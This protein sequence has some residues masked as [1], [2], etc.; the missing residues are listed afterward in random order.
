VTS[1]TAAA[2]SEPPRGAARRRLIVEGAL[3][4]LARVGP[5]GLTHRLVAA[6]AGVPLAATTYWFASKEAIVEAA[7]E[8]SVEDSL[9][10]IAARREAARTWTRASAAHELALVIQQECSTDREQTVVG[11][12]LWV[13]ALRR[14]AL[15]P[16]AQR[17]TDAYVDLYREI[18]VIVGATGDVE[19]RARL[20]G[21]AVDGLVSQQLASDDPLAPATVAAVLAPLFAE[22]A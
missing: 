4:V 16:I 19:A 11:Y 12:A 15:R 8:R 18:L 14:P 17:W 3:A 6:E 21:A 1:T 20:L 5:D 22:P 13:E 9:A 7:L 10:G 2:T